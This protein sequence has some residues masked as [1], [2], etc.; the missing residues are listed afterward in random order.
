MITLFF[1]NSGDNSLL[2]K[3]KGFFECNEGIECFGALVG[4]LSASSYFSF[5]TF[6]SYRYSRQDVDSR[7]I[8]Y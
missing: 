3:F 4:F 2:N 5:P 6:Q 8:W 7:V 1:T